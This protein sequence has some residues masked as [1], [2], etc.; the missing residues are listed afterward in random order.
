MEKYELSLQNIKKIKEGKEKF[1]EKYK[2]YNDFKAECIILKNNLNKYK[3]FITIFYKIYQQKINDY[4]GQDFNFNFYRFNDYELEEIFEVKYK[5][6]N[7]NELSSTL[8]KEFDEI[9]LEKIK[10]FS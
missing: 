8:R 6:I 5:G 4:F 7:Y 9:Y 10:Y 3:K 1:Q 2:K